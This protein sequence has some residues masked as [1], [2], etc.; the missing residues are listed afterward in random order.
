MP[1]SGFSHAARMRAGLLTLISG[2]GLL[3][4]CNLFSS[5]A[6]DGEDLS[7][8]G[9]ILK[10]NQAVNHGK[11]AAAEDYF[12]RVMRKNHRGAEA[13]LYH[14]K[15]LMSLYGISY[16][17][18]NDEFESRRNPDG[19]GKKGIPFIDSTTTLEGID[20]IFYPVAQ[21]VEN[22]EHI[23]RRRSDTVI[24]SGNWVMLPD[25]DTADDG[26][27]SEGV[28]RLDLGLLQTIKGMLGPLDLDG[29]NRLGRECGRGICPD[30]DGACVT[31]K[32]YLETCKEGP[33]SEAEGFERFKRLVRNIN[34]DDLN[35]KDINARELS[36]DPN[37][38]NGF[39]DRMQGPIA[40]SNYH[41]DSVAGALDSHGQT[42]LGEELTEIVATVGDLSGFLGF[43]RYN[44]GLDNDFDG[45][46]GAASGGRMI[47]HDYDKDGGIRFDYSDGATFDGYGGGPNEA[48]V[49]IGHPLHRML[50][51]ELYVRFA[52]SE[53]SG[54]GIAADT[55]SNG[56]KALMIKHCRTV[57]QGLYENGRK[58]T[59][60]LKRELVSVTCAEFTSF[61]KASVT[62]PARSDWVAGSFGID[63]EMIDDRDNDYDGIKDEDG[64]NG[65]GMDDDDDALLKPEMIDNG[66]DPME[67]KDAAGH[68]N[69][70]PDIDT[71]EA[72]P[73]APF[74]RRFCIGSLEHRIHLARNGGVGSLRAR[75]SEF[76]GEGA[77]RNCLDDFRK[78]DPAYREAIGAGSGPD[79][80][81]QL[82]CRFKHI[83][84][85]DRPGN[86]EWT[87]GVFGID[88]EFPDGVD[89]DGDGWID[90]DVK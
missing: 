52:D 56:R 38:I 73:D 20:S 71:T 57:A 33:A 15:A 50:R 47:W 4:G 34:I 88:E 68:E 8:R 79:A 40:G 63:E 54:L 30:L 66:P 62:P 42:S 48:A 67:W 53:W 9:L 43:M 85:A 45:Q 55:S 27:V 10:G 78:L 49:N 1:G 90:E 37:D 41:L 16:K 65:K 18:L 58:V 12:H 29:D 89:N 6:D 70:C 17:T 23:L 82:A 61:L 64:R 11:F 32:A 2:L 51:P 75:Y 26:K 74:Q 80:S 44:D 3:S 83:W 60:A 5:L 69:R 39:L 35:S 46:R 86:S 25:G 72:M 81:V 24:L 13:Y 84:I 76:P 31:G 21:S 59:A 77:D 19:K 22:L 36:A 28:A 7:Y 87:S 14:S